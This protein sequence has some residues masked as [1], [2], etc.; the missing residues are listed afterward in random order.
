MNFTDETIKAELAVCEAAKDY[1]RGSG[2][3]VTFREH[4]CFYYKAALEE[5][6]VRELALIIASKHKPLGCPAAENMHQK[7]DLSCCDWLSGEAGGGEQCAHS[8]NSSY[9]WRHVYKEMARKSLDMSVLFPSFEAKESEPHKVSEPKH[10]VMTTDDLVN[11]LQYITT[12]VETHDS[13]EG[14]LEY[15][16]VDRSLKPGEWLVKAA[17][18]HGN[19]LGQ[20]SMLIVESDQ[21]GENE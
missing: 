14:C 13:F 3:V 1:K 8:G 12:E 16:C 19:Q 7:V 20:G 18:R 6:L 17:I 9:C 2:P 21:Q 4:A 5:L 10:R 15:S 11:L